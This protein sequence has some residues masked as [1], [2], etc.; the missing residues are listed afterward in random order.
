MA[1]KLLSSIYRD[2]KTDHTVR[3]NSQSLLPPKRNIYLSCANPQKNKA[4]YQQ[5][6]NLE[7]WR[8]S[9]IKVLVS[10]GIILGSK[11]SNAWAYVTHEMHFSSNA[12]HLVLS[13]GNSADDHQS[14]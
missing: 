7:K 13:L 6:K 12:V 3:S 11:K 2:H 10:L 5:R 8:N 14:F 9:Q 4:K 1:K